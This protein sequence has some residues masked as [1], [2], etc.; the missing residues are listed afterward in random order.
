MAQA[1]AN[2]PVWEQNFL[3][4][5]LPANYF[6]G[7][8]ANASLIHV[9]TA[10]MVGVLKHLHRALRDRGALVMSMMRGDF[11]GFLERPVGARYVVAWEYETLAPCLEAAGFEMV[12]RYYR[13]PGL[14]IEEQFWLVIVAQKSDRQG[15]D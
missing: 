11:E 8:F 10:E 13:P 6:D 4:L 7:V 3:D 1:A 12:D 2:C 9:P 5:D 15:R 14:P